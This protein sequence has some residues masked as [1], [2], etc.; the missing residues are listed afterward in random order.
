M[1]SDGDDEDEDEEEMPDWQPRQGPGSRNAASFKSP[2]PLQAGLRATR[3]L[4]NQTDQPRGTKRSRNGENMELDSEVST[5]SEPDHSPIPLIARNTAAKV[6]PASLHESDEMI[7][8]TED[9]MGRLD[10]SDMG[11]RRQANPDTLSTVTGELVRFWQS[12]SDYDG[13]TGQDGRIGPGEDASP[14][15]KASYLGELLLQ[16]HHP[17]GLELTDVFLKY[18]VS[19]LPAHERSSTSVT[20]GRSL[21]LPKVLIDW[22]DAHHNPLPDAL[23]EV[24]SHKPN[25]AEHGYFW[26]IILAT[27]LRGRI[28]EAIQLLKGANFRHPGTTNRTQPE[29]T[30]QR[31]SYVRE[32][33]K[34]VIQ[35]LEQCPVVTKGDWTLIGNDWAVFRLKAS[36]ASRDLTSVA[37]QIDL[38]RDIDGARPTTFSAEHFGIRKDQSS[39]YANANREAESRIPWK[40]YRNLK[41]LYGILM[42]SAPDIMAL[43]QDWLEATIG[44]TVWWDGQSD[45]SRDRST[46]KGRAGEGSNVGPDHLGRLAWAFDHATSEATQGS[47]KPN[48]LNPIELGLA[49]IFDGDVE[50]VVNVVRMWS[51]VVASSIVRIG[52]RGGWLDRDSSD[53][54]TTD[55]DQ[56][57]L[58][59]LSYDQADAPSWKD[60]VLVGYANALLGR[61][62]LRGR[63]QGRNGGRIQDG[64]PVEREGWQLAIHVLAQLAHAQFASK[65]I[66][67]LVDRI[68]L[69]SATQVDKLIDICRSIGLNGQADKVAEVSFPILR[70]HLEL[71]DS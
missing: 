58:M 34:R 66:T 25:P 48:T 21:P 61:G 35:T 60:E 9:Q 44:L 42:G 49:C 15:T 70:Q 16:L 31:L 30:D 36:M 17:P 4:A 2:F 63:R 65:K 23:N 54:M 57:D 68:E 7:L 33:I 32:A 26:E 6:G 53:K 39:Y 62:H 51:M 3:P 71:L 28:D 55:F 18:Y 43:A 10:S 64:P 29:Q 38:I 22:L 24:R 47:F 50:A 69:E 11:D 13:P 1:G 20:A 12:L 37:E 27:I 19:R 45:V 40:I 67:E 5:S 59:V 8:G 41:S 46:R 52:R 56:S 14:I